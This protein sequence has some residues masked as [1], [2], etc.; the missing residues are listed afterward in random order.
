[1]MIL[2][3]LI[4]ILLGLFWVGAMVFTTF[5]LFPSLMGDPA[6]MGKVVQGLM[7]RRFMMIMPLVAIFTILSGAAMLWI[8]SGGQMDAYMQT[9]A[10]RTFSMAGG[11]AILAFVLGITMARPAGMKAAALGA[12]M[13]SV[14]EPT[15]RARLQA[16]MAALQ[17]TN[18]MIT[19]LVTLMV[20]LAAAGMAIARYV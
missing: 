5:F 11:L 8:T 1:M 2:L 4:H 3:R 12:R 9:P 19:V 17:K 10:G 16:E 14:T 15:E 7:K 18:G 20:L 13:A 6:T